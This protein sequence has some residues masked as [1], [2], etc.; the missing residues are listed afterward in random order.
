[1]ARAGE[2]ESVKLEH[3]SICFITFRFH[4][5]S[6][7]IANSHSEF[8]LL[9]LSF[10]LFLSACRVFFCCHIFHLPCSPLLILLTIDQKQHNGEEKKT[11]RKKK[12]ILH[13]LY[14]Y[15]FT[16]SIAHFR[17]SISIRVF[18]VA[19][20]NRFFFLPLIE[21]VPCSNVRFFSSLFYRMNT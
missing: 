21:L 9:F 11:H 10:S 4:I 16:Y 17:Y 3:E 6:S 8:V 14:I 7:S 5:N 2:A 12:Y 13:S 1:M 19:S 15:S 20:A 18:S